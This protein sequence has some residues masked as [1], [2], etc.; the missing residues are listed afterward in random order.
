ML[1]PVLSVPYL[2]PNFTLLM[3]VFLLFIKNE[4]KFCSSIL[5]LEGVRRYFVLLLCIWWLLFVDFDS[6]HY[7]SP[8][9]L[10]QNSTAV[11][12]LKNVDT[13]LSHIPWNLW[14]RLLS[15]LLSHK[16]DFFIVAFW[17][18]CFI[19]NLKCL[20]GRMLEPGEEGKAIDSFSNGP[21]LQCPPSSSSRIR[22]LCVLNCTQGLL[23]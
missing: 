22:F 9:M 6:Y 11:T 23:N 2:K 14:N 17:R 13:L 20:S 21:I 1:L 16:K 12:S 5:P 8:D 19:I 4:C 3:L 10:L 7:T 15:G 18:G